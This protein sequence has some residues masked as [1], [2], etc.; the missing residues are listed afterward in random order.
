MI[1]EAFDVGNVFWKVFLQ[2][3]EKDG[4]RTM[5]ISIESFTRMIC[6]IIPYVEFKTLT[7]FYIIVFGH[8]KLAVVVVVIYNE[9]E[10]RHTI[11]QFQRFAFE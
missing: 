5:N 1:M 6:F 7:T 3:P 8:D 9:P 10:K 2:E 11:K 4:D